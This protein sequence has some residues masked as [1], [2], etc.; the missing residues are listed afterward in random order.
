MTRPKDGQII[1]AVDLFC[2]AGGLTRG[3]L[4]AGIRVRAGFDQDAACR[5]AYEYNNAGAAFH[6]ADVAD[7]TSS[8]IKPFWSEGAIRLL[9]GCAPCQPF[10]T[11]ANSRRGEADSRYDLLDHFSRLV[12]SCLPELVTMENVPRV[13][14]H[15]PFSRFIARLKR[16]GY[17]VWT[18]TVECTT[19]GVPQTRKRLVVLASRLGK[20]DRKLRVPK[21]TGAL[22]V[23][24][25]IGHLPVLAAGDQDPRD[26][27]HMA[28]T[29]SP[30]NME[31]MEA[32][33]PGGTWKDWPAD[34]LNPCHTKES[35][36]SY[37]SVYGR[38]RSDAPSPTITTLFFNF[39]TGRFGHYCQ[40]RA[41]TPRE[42]AILQSFPESYRF[43]ADGVPAQFSTLGRLIGNAVPPRLGEAIGRTF[44]AHASM[45][46][47]SLEATSR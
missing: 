46:R 9:A 39:G 17:D 29:L 4:D 25:A 13:K 11:A 22:T 24:S 36:H 28:R 21:P 45:H 16:Y 14:N 5:F 3:L 6:L 47:C 38:M 40:N 31:R 32:S 30:T 15:P 20:L 34:L 23:E 37:R 2:G 43:T 18:E 41:I 44:V 19:V 10:S 7:L 12:T 42:A 26:Q 27:I 8:D 35:G 1:E 33:K